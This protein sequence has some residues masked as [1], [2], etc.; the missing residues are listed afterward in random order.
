MSETTPLHDVLQKTGAVFATGEARLMP[1]HFGNATAEYEAARN[2]AVVF[3][4]SASSKVALAG[5]DAA[6]FLHNLCSNDIA[7]L[8]TGA[9]CEAFLATHKA[10]VVAHLA[11]SRVRWQGSEELWLDTAPGHAERIVQHLDHYLISE[12]VE[13]SDRT[14]GLAMLRVLGPA[15]ATIVG[16]ALQAASAPLPPW[17]HIVRA[18]PGG[19]VVVRFHRALGALGYDCFC[20]PDAAPALWER[21]VHAG[22]KPMGTQAHEVLRVEAGFPAFG[23]EL[24]ENRFVVEV[25]R[26]DAISYTKGCYLGQ[27]PIVMARDRGQANRLLLGLLAGP[28][29]ALAPG[30]GLV[31]DG[32]E[33]GQVTSSA[34][35][36]HL[37]QVVALAYLRR[38]HQKPGTELTVA[39][40]EAGRKAVVS[41][42]P[43][44]P[45]YEL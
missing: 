24:D 22:A 32:A 10:R 5:P 37:K 13:I 7:G 4:G 28:G 36:P 23:A 17:H 39:P 27:E 11:V 6:T 41:L 18:G 20:A 33:A 26:T 35:S 44:S 14:G 42:L 40:P 3:D 29:E 31:H 38:G 12:Q 25:G 45:V 9:G 30:T 8:A 1:L 21:L 15:A 43:I 16:Q 19:D 2:H 34:W